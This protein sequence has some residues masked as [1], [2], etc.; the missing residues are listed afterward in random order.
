MDLIHA[1]LYSKES[2]SLKNQKSFL[3]ETPTRPVPSLPSLCL[4]PTSANSGFNGAGGGQRTWH[5]VTAPRCR[6]SLAEEVL[7]CHIPWWP[8]EGRREKGPKAE[9]A[10]LSHGGPTWAPARGVLSCTVQSLTIKN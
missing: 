6:L 3:P 2:R 1:G 10:E 5:L 9:Q 4:L 8:L 7:E